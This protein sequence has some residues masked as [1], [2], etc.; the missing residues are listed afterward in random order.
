MT[1]FI[2]FLIAIVALA[3]IGCW[4]I[5]NEAAERWQK[6]AEDR[7]RENDT[8]KSEVDRLRRKLK[9]IRIDTEDIE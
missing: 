3:G 4:T 7:E 1:G 2:A 5:N 9:W 8:L 6:L